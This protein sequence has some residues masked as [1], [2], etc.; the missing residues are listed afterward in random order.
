MKLFGSR[1]ELNAA[2]QAQAALDTAQQKADRLSAQAAQ[3]QS[4]LARVKQQAA[5]AASLES[6][7]ALEEAAAA[8]ST[9]VATH[10]ALSSALDTAVDELHQAE[11][12][13][14]H[15]IDCAQRTA[16]I[17]EVRGLVDQI[18]ACSQPLT[19]AVGTLVKVLQRAAP[20]THDARNVCGFFEVVAGDL[21]QMIA[22]AQQ[23]LEWHIHQIE[24]GA[25][26][27]T[28]PAPEITPVATS[29]LAPPMRSIMPIFDISFTDSAGQQ[30][31]CARHWDIGLP[32][33][34]AERAIRC[35]IAYPSE[36]Q[37][38][39]KLR[40]ARAGGPVCNF[41][42]LVNLDDTDP[43]PPAPDPERWIQ[44]HGTSWQPAGSVGALRPWITP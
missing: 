25:A 5:D 35:G 19:S 12:T 29:A 10:E 39:T 9:A 11:T 8:V 24:S 27:A 4:E 16:S 7:F 43:R 36:D 21:P 32:V 15:E 3:A 37:R 31:H 22:S 34:L 18:E 14:A 41:D 44:P 1:A 23:A 13:L 42:K 20:I 38:A 28:L 40:A 33:I 6:P 2:E 17:A 26:R 30:R